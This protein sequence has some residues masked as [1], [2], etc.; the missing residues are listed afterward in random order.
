[1]SAVRTGRSKR[2]LCRLPP[3]RRDLRSKRNR[4]FRDKANLCKKD[5]AFC[6]VFFAR[7]A[8][9]Q[10]KTDPED[11]KDTQQRKSL[12]HFGYE[13][14]T[15]YIVAYCAED[16]NGV[17]SDVRFAEVTT[18]SAT[19]GPNPQAQIAADLVDGKWMFTFTSNDDTG[20]MLYMT[21]SYGDANYDLLG[22]PY[23]LNDPYDDYPTYDS[24]FDLWD[25]KIMNLGLSTKSLTTYATEDAR[26]DDDNSI[27]LALCLPVGQNE[28]GKEEY[29]PLQHLLIVDGQVKKLDDYRTK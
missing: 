23:I 29:G 5:L 12:T 24:L 4:F 26:D 2:L 7:S 22:L 3:P 14:G 9:P 17:I 15:K 18:L 19:P 13:P 8:N 16:M 21:S 25:E 1:M 10:M 27:I 6:R 20:T 28:Q 11:E